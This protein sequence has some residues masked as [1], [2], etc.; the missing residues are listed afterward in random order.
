MLCRTITTLLKIY[1]K[2]STVDTSLYDSKYIYLVR[3]F[4]ITS[5]LLY[6][7]PIRG[8]FDVD[9]LVIKLRAIDN[10]AYSNKTEIYSFL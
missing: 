7:V 2:S 9:S 4:T 10:H 5:M 1:T 8:F 3:V 6:V